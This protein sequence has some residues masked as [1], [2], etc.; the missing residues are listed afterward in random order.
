MF[1]GRNSTRSTEFFLKQFSL[2]KSGNGAEG[3]GKLAV[4]HTSQQ[5]LRGSAQASL[6]DRASGHEAHG[7]LGQGGVTS[8]PLAL[9]RTHGLLVFYRPGLLVRAE[10]K[11][12]TQSFLAEAG[13]WAGGPSRR[14]GL[15][16]RL[17]P[18][19]RAA[20]AAQLCAQS[21]ARLGLSRGP[22]AEAQATPR[23]PSGAGADLC[24]ISKARPSSRGRPSPGGGSAGG[25]GSA[26]DAATARTQ[27][28]R[29]GHTGPRGACCTARRSLCCCCRRARGLGAGS[30]PHRWPA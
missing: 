5:A 10:D 29:A 2:H 4:Q 14:R 26:R 9:S 12:R 25:R 16:P 15:K 24:P 27:A 30:T 17:C 19:E 13:G 7:T 23:E 3:S 1:H 21:G 6:R 8:R 28:R 22:S 11:N 20:G 18:R